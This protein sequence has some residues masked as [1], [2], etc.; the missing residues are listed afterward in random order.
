MIRE[1]RRG[2]A[3]AVAALEVA[4]NPHQVVT[5]EIVWQRANRT[6]AREQRRT[7]V[8]EVDGSIAGTAFAGFEWSVPTEGK[9]R[10]WIGVHPELRHRGIGSA[11]YGEIEEYLRG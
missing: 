1:L 11:F 6:I 9:G 2:D 3:A 5:P 8:A 7:W 4:V 10:F